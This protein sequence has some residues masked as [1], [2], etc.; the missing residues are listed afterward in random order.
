MTAAG[1]W[2]SRPLRG[3]AT[4]AP[5]I[6]CCRARSVL[7]GSAMRA[8]ARGVGSSSP[9]T[10]PCSVRRRLRISREG[11]RV[12][13]LAAGEKWIRTIGPAL[14]LAGL[15]ATGQEAAPVCIW[16]A[17]TGEMLARLRGH[18]QGVN[19]ATWSPPPPGSTGNGDLFATCSFDRTIQIW[20]TQSW[21]RTQVLEGHNDDIPDVGWSP[22][23]RMLASASADRTIKIWDVAKGEPIVTWHHHRDTVLRVVWLEGGAMLASCS[24]DGTVR[25]RRVSNMEYTTSC[26]IRVSPRREGVLALCASPDGQLLATCTLD[27]TVQIWDWLTGSLVRKLGKQDG[28]RPRSALASGECR[29][30]DGQAAAGWGSDCFQCQGNSSCSLAA[31]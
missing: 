15:H 30:W 2:G 13:R 12:C 7:Q 24:W 4:A 5:S 9:S 17:E 8:P 18:S 1:Q 6:G 31:G 26:Q 16:D 23:G 21:E 25:I 19:Q 10:R 27:G 29:G 28:N 3:L 14:P 20:S 22:D 11:R